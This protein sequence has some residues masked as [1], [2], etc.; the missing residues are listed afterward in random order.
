V[1]T[2]NCV[3]VYFRVVWTVTRSIETGD[4]PRWPEGSSLVL[5]DDGPES[6]RLGVAHRSAPQPGQTGLDSQMC[7]AY[8]S[9]GHR[10][11]L[12]QKSPTDAVTKSKV[13]T[14]LER[15]LSSESKLTDGVGPR[16]TP[17]P[18]CCRSVEWEARI[19][20]E[21]IFTSRLSMSQMGSRWAAY[22]ALGLPSA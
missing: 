6:P 9:S 11:S 14:P 7:R 13:G 8:R 3:S 22:A 16:L 1:L 21:P 2:V 18:W 12:N 19:S 10:C 17:G 15:S 5:L 4:S 20:T